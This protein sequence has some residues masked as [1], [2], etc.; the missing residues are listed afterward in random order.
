[1]NEEQAT[2]LMTYLRNSEVVRRFKKELVQQFYEMREFLREKASTP[3]K[4]I[5][6]AEKQIRRLETVNDLMVLGK[7]NVTS[8]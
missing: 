1:M 7:G 2:L 4:E 8:A 3:Y 6:S 5:Q